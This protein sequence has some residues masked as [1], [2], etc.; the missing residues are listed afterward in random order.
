MTTTYVH[1][2]ICNLII[3]MLVSICNMYVCRDAMMHNISCHSYIHMS[4]GI[5]KIGVRKVNLRDCN[6]T[7]ITHYFML[8]LVVTITTIYVT[9]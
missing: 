4:R 3:L 2:S 1:T 5:V 9:V 8:W 6:Y 7:V